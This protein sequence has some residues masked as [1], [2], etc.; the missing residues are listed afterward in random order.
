MESTTHNKSQIIYGLRNHNSTKEFQDGLVDLVFKQAKNKDEVGD[1]KYIQIPKGVTSIGNLAFG[2]CNSLTSM[3]I[4]KGVKSI[5]RGAFSN[6]NNLTSITIPKGVTSIG[7]C[8]FNNCESLTSI[9]I[10]PI[11]L[12]RFFEFSKQS[13]IIEINN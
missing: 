3:V 10:P 12:S 5:E 6:C 8:A 9:T 4:P 7:A 2:I 11:C 13:L 1:N